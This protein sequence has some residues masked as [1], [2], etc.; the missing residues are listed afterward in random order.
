MRE[1]LKYFFLGF[2]AAVVLGIVFHVLLNYMAGHW[3]A[4]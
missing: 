3:I 1:K 4:G 2:A